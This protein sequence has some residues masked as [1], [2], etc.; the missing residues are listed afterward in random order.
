MIGLFERLLEHLALLLA[1]QGCSFSVPLFDLGLGWEDD[2][3]VR[4]GIP[5]DLG[6]ISVKQTKRGRMTEVGRRGRLT[7]D[8]EIRGVPVVCLDQAFVHF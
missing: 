3:R 4:Y 7:T 8:D 1:I 5:K 2:H 6:R